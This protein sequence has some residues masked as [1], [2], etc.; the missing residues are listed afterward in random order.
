MSKVYFISD[1]HLGLGTKE[2][3]RKKE[4][5]LLSFL[6]KIA[7][8]ANSIYILGDL[9][10]AWFEYKTV[11]PR[12]FHRILSK[13]DDL[14]QNNITIHYLAGN[15]DYWMNDFFSKEIGIKTYL[16]AFDVDIDGKKIYLHHGDGLANN[17]NGYL[18]L[19]KVFRNPINIKLFKL[20]HPDLAIKIARKFSKTSRKYSHNKHFGEEDGMQNTAAKKIEAGY[21]IIIMGHRHKPTLMNINNGIYINLGDWITHYTYCEMT[22]GVPV[23]KKWSGE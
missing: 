19:K 2:E 15:H 11:I 18:I 1:A 22:D 16:E 4:N 9:F 14:V 8:D 20:L 12:G 5:K 10:D 3:E 7:D 13:L 17:D 21:D 23:I 6:G